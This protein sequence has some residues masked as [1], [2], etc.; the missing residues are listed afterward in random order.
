MEV[1]DILYIND[2]LQENIVILLKIWYFL[3]YSFERYYCHY[4]NNIN[5]LGNCEVVL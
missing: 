3:H 1:L 5:M 2:K 4:D